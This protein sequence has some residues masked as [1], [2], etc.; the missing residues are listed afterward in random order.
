MRLVKRLGKRESGFT[1][2]EMMV[3][4]GILSILAMIAIP[5]FMTL[6]PG[7]RLKSSAREIFMVLNQIKM[8]AVAKNS[9]GVIRFDSGNSWTAWLDDG[10]LGNNWWYDGDDTPIKSGSTEEN[11]VSISTNI[12]YNTYGYNS[13]GLPAGTNTSAYDITLTNS[14]GDTQLVQVNAVGAI[15]MP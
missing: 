3:T 9:V 7:M 14:K 12:P 13:R 2:T 1:L 6:L 15:K 11:G 5:N 4:I 8:R 10:Q